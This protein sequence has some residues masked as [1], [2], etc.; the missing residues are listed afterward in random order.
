MN[1]VEHGM[2]EYTEAH[3]LGARKAP[4]DSTDEHRFLDEHESHSNGYDKNRKN[5]RWYSLPFGLCN[6]LM[7]SAYENTFSTRMP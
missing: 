2:Q 5:P 6:A 4:T 3:L 1:K 7:P